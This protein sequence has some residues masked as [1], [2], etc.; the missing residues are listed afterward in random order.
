MALF[1]HFNLTNFIQIL[2]KSCFPLYYNQLQLTNKMISN[3]FSS[4][5]LQIK[6]SELISIEHH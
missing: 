6:L 2:S 1:L 4:L 5:E 3:N